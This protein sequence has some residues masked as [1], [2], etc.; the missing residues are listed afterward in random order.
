M[1]FCSLTFAFS[2]L[3]FK[4]PLCCTKG[5]PRGNENSG[6]D[7]NSGYRTFRNFRSVSGQLVGFC[8]GTKIPESEHSGIFASYPP[9]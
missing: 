7:E 2:D 5:A 1:H 8:G 3:F 9:S 4:F 6:R